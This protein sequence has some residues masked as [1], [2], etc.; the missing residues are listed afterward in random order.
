[1]EDKIKRE[2]REAREND[3][4]CMMVRHPELAHL[5]E[6]DLKYDRRSMGRYFWSERYRKE[7]R[8]ESGSVC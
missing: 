7:V 6:K 8:D 3:C 5:I 2:T 4:L 1:M